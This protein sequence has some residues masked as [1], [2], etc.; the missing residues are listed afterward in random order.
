MK[1]VN[2]LGV[3]VLIL[4][5]FLIENWKRL[6]M[7]VDFLMKFLEEFL[8][9]YFLEFVEENVQ[10]WIIGDKMV[11]LVYILCVIEKVVEDMV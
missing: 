5:V 7:E 3:K 11:L 8:N 6:K 2:E 1:F 9:M 4:Y 10:V